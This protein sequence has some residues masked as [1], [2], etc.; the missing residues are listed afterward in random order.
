[1]QGVDR[2]IV[3]RDR[4]GFLPC[5]YV[6]EFEGGTIS[7]VPNYDEVLALVEQHTH[8]DGFLYPPLA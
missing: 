5:E 1:M 8:E 2:E 6:I 7:P 4:F 3:V